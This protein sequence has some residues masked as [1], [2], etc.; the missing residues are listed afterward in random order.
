MVLSEPFAVGDV[1][2]AVCS[3][4]VTTLAPLEGLLMATRQTIASRLKEAREALGWTQAEVAGRLRIPRPRLA[5]IESGERPID[6]VLLWRFAEAYGKRLI[7][8]LSE[9][10]Q[11]SLSEVLFRGQ[12]VPDEA[13]TE[14]QRAYSLALE[15]AA[16]E[17][18]LGIR[19]QCVLCC[20]FDGG[21]D[22]VEEGESLARQERSR[23]GLGEAP[24]EDIFGLVESQGVRAF[25]LNCDTQD[26]DGGF[27]FSDEAGPCAFIATGERQPSFRWRFTVAH[28]YC[29]TLVD[30]NQQGTICSASFDSA[31]KHAEK[32]ANAFAAAFLMPQHAFEEVIRELGRRPSHACLADVVRVMWHFRVSFHA[33]Y[34]RLK[35]LGLSRELLESVSEAKPFLVEAMRKLGYD[36]EAADGPFL[37]WIDGGHKR[38]LCQLAVE[39][40]RQS[41]ISLGKVSE[42]LDVSREQAAE[43]LEAFDIPLRTVEY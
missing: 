21:R 30:R 11:F 42:L 27:F 3:V 15:C 17:R 8:F 24:I 16:L 33:V 2:E 20:G 29:H 43:L 22:P 7:E 38:R 39:A 12:A 1:L 35:K 37:E 28:E 13:K 26:L 18:R 4:S 25:P 19:R 36:P 14:L 32:R 31:R 10:P 9:G 23:L 5:L 41:L 40:Y 34:Y 6:S